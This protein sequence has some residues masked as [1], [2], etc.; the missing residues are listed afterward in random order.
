LG[1]N[2]YLEAVHGVDGEVV[3]A[4]FHPVESRTGGAEAA[5]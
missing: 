4:D 3:V 2:V 5:L 1:K